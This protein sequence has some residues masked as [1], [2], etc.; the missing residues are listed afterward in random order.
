MNILALI[1]LKKIP[2]S[3]IISFICGELW[4][5]LSMKKNDNQVWKMLFLITQIGFT[6]LT[7]IFMSIAIGYFLGKWLGKNLV[8][9]FIVIGVIAGVR[10]VYIL[11]KKYLEK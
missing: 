1:L 9:W 10:S 8:G 2:K 6:M 11:I 7:T 4:G 3:F 5:N